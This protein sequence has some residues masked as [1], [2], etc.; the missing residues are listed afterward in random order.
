MSYVIRFYILLWKENSIKNTTDTDL[1]V[2]I[3]SRIQQHLHHGFVPADAGVHERSHSLREE[4]RQR[5]HQQHNSDSALLPKRQKYLMKF[6][7]PAPAGQR[8]VAM[9]MRRNAGEAA[10]GPNV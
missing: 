6:A 9:A 7:A 5:G 2:N 1:A 4:E 8:R 3:S 10:G